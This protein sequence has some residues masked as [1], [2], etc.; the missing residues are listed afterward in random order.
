MELGVSLEEIGDALGI[1]Y[2]T[3]RATR[4]DPD[5]AN[6]RR[7]PE[8]WRPKLAALARERGGELQ[9]LAEELEATGASS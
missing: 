5:S 4:L 7:P 2:T 6:Y 8:E 9:G 3:V 1:A